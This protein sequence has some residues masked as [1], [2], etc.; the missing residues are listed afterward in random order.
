MAQ[1][2]LLFLVAAAVSAPVPDAGYIEDVASR[3][4]FFDAPAV[5]PWQVMPST[6]SS[7][8]SGV[9]PLRFT[10]DGPVYFALYGG[11]VNAS[12]VTFSSLAPNASAAV[13]SFVTVDVRT[14]TR[15]P[16]TVAS[17]SPQCYGCA[18]NLG[19][20]VVAF[21]TDPSSLVVR[22]YVTAEGVF[23]LQCL[24]NAT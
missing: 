18:C 23:G 24:P 16:C 21:L 6:V 17:P 14:Y 2:A 8:A 9:Q 5:A 15:T 1:L 13:G 12:A 7:S 20:P 11:S 3:F 19:S 22:A 10:D 4:T